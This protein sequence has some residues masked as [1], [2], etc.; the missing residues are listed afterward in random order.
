M[1]GGLGKYFVDQSG[2]SLRVRLPNDD[3]PDKHL[4]EVTT[5]AQVV[6]RLGSGPAH[7]GRSRVWPERCHG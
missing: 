2:L 6:E 7:L 4:I 5:K 3:S 1:G